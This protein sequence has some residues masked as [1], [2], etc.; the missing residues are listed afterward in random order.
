MEYR[1][2]TRAFEHRV[3]GTR[4]RVTKIGCTSWSSTQV[5]SPGSWHKVVFTWTRNMAI[6]KQRSFWKSMHAI[7]AKLPHKLR[8]RWKSIA[9]GILDKQ[10]RRAKFS[11]LVEL[12][13]KQA[14]EALHP[15][16]GNIT[17]GIK[18]Q[19]TVYNK[20]RSLRKSG[21]QRGFTTAT[22][23]ERIKWKRS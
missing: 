5:D 23:V 15:P 12:V 7:I 8:E 21:N 11:D 6:E 16:F 9:Y 20:E 19:A 1:P 2:F 22:T 17:D 14:K 3:G 4:H 18:S 13:N 10:Q